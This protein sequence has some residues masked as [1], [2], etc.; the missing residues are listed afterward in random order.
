VFSIGT[1]PVFCTLVWLWRVSIKPVLITTPRDTITVH[2]L[3]YTVSRREITLAKTLLKS[4]RALFFRCDG[5]CDSIARC[6]DEDMF[7]WHTEARFPSKRNRLRC[8][9]CKQQPIGCS[10][11]AVAAMIGCLP[12]QALAF[13]PVSIQ[14][15]RTQRTQRKR[16]RLDGNRAWRTCSS[17]RH[18][19]VFLHIIYTEMMNEWECLSHTRYLLRGWWLRVSRSVTQSH[20]SKVSCTQL[21]ASVRHTHTHL[22]VVE[23]RLCMMWARCVRACVLNEPFNCVLTAAPFRSHVDILSRADDSVTDIQY[24]NWRRTLAETH[25][26]ATISYCHFCVS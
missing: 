26:L 24:R 4:L 5:T 19:Q 16:L 10:V 7:Y 14:T 6:R 13:S 12:T 22:A 21:A 23:C 1:L 11:E 15:Q 9:R 17:V 2:A 8:V 18:W 3:W 25:A 20:L